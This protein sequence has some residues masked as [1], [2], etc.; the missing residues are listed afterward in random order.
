MLTVFWRCKS[1]PFLTDKEKKCAVGS[2]WLYFARLYR[3]CTNVQWNTIGVNPVDG[4]EI[5]SLMCA[6]PVDRTVETDLE[7]ERVKTSNRHDL[8]TQN[9]CFLL[10]AGTTKAVENPCTG[11]PL[12]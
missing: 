4:Y 6:S 2:G 3:G 11:F 1:R 9:L 12:M 7:H 10:T 5:N 8:R